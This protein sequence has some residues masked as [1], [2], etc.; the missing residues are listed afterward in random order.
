MGNVYIYGLICP[1][2][3][4]I[5]YVGK[6]INLK[7]RLKNHL[8]N[9]NHSNGPH[10]KNWIKKLLSKNIFPVLTV[11]EIS[12]NENWA[13]REKYWIRYLKNKGN[14]LTNIS[15]GGRGITTGRPLSEETKKKIGDANRGRR[16]TEETKK[17]IRAKNIGR[18]LTLVQRKKLSESLKKA[19][20]S[21]KIG[22]KLSE[23][24]KSNISVAL[25]GKKKPL[26]S[27]EHAAKIAAANKGRVP[28]NKGKKHTEETKAKMRKPHNISDEQ[29]QKMRDRMIGK[30]PANKGKM[31]PLDVRE[32]QSEA[33]K[34]NPTRYWLDKH[35]SEE[36]K[37]KIRQANLGK[38]MLEETKQKI[39]DSLICY[40]KS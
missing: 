10:R 38:K 20:H 19:D 2:G 39:K 34:K 26:R 3:Q 32:K 9:V 13:E 36:T 23:E 37:E 11:L 31:T 7:S 12:N 30:E 15:I 35:H 24:H 1:L 29:R 18:I 22:C 4:E 33:H 27:K 28:P 21:W 40:H 25:K 5:R 8:F 17:K 16:H 6:T 14:N